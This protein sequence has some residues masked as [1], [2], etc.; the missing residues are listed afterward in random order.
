MDEFHSLL[1]RQLARH[2]GKPADMPDDLLPL[3]RAVDSAYREFDADRAMLERSLDL[4]STELLHANSEMRAVFLAIPD[5]LF[6]TNLEGTILDYKA[7]DDVDFYLSP[8]EMRGKRIQDVP[9]REAAERFESALK[10]VRDTKTTATIEYRL[11][12][13]GSEQWYEAR[14]A[15]LLEAQLIV[16]IRNITE[17]KKMQASLLVADHMASMGTI[18]AGVAHELNNPLSYVITNLS[19]A[20][21]ELARLSADPS[22]QQKLVRAI[23]ALR[24]AEEG[25]VRVRQI[26]R[27]LK[28]FSRT[29]EEQRDVIDVRTVMES[30]IKLAWSEIK[31]RAKVVREY[32]PAPPV[33]ANPGR[34]GQVFL[35]LLVNAAQSIPDGAAEENTIRI[36]TGTDIEGRAAIEISDTGCGMSEDVRER[37]FEPFFTTKPIGVGTGL[38]LAICHGIVAAIGGKIEVESTEGSGSTFRVV[39][40]SA[41]STGEG[42]SVGVATPLQAVGSSRVLIIDDEPKIGLALAR[43]IE[44]LH[45]AVSVTSAAQALARIESGEHFDV[46][47]CDLMMPEMTGMEF[48]AR[49]VST[50]PQLQDRI[51]FITGG[52]FT[53]KARAF[54]E[55]VPNR[56]MEKPIDIDR[57][58]DLI[59]DQRL[60]SVRAG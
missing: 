12:L 46:I 11:D 25:A 17:R 4:S 47:L 53:P 54:L 6:R 52:A 58:L 3:L 21:R 38:G 56:R 24:D 34:V 14:L 13:R 28:A 8:R 59:R 57:L 22:A 19:F 7:G 10:L 37:A 2:F 27:D 18:A 32:A 1:R 39:L 31:H 20:A 42:S 50:L 29:D 33:L 41:A 48:H 26:V 55:R 16:M 44:H 51:V 23:D 30:A 45:E 35:N 60:T 15:P 36:V 43:A 9:A 5:V 49:V 40:P